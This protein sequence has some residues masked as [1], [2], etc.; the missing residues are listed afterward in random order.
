VVDGTLSCIGQRLDI[1]PGFNSPL[2]VC[3][4]CVQFLGLVLQQCLLCL[5]FSFL[6]SPGPTFC[7][8]FFGGCQLDLLKIISECH[9]NLFIKKMNS[10]FGLS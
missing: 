2:K 9:F 5:C 4:I 10:H 1:K 8:G 6:F 7:T 3:T